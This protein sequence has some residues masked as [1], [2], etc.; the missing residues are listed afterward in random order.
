[1]AGTSTR[2]LHPVCPS[3][4]SP[5]LT[6]DVILQMRRRIK[7]LEN[8]NRRLVRQAALQKTREATFHTHLRKIFTADQ[9]L[10]LSR[11][12][13]RGSKWSN[14]TVKKSLQMR[15]ACGSTGYDLMLEG[16]FPLPSS[17]TLRRRLEGKFVLG[18]LICL[19]A[20][21]WLLADVISL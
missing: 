3:L 16:G 11:T 17:R 15:F 2:T 18:L 13:N 6:E 12:S 1:M 4:I 8:E 10:A 20:P 5:R 21:C 19:K 7:H 14:E 9:L